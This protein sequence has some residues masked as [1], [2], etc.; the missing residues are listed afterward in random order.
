MKQMDAITACRRRLKHILYTD[1]A[2]LYQGAVASVCPVCREPIRQECDM[3]EVLITRGDVQNSP[4]N[5]RMAVFARENCVLVHHGLCHQQ[6]QH[7]LDSK[8][9]CVLQL[10]DEEGLEKVFIWLDR[11]SGLMTGR[12]P[13]EARRFVQTV[14]ENNYDIFYEVY[15]RA[16]REVNSDEEAALP[17]Y[18][19]FRSRWLRPFYG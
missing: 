5:V 18:P 10:I 14:E 7:S 1:R 11:V 16:D 13:D 17:N 12:F 8:R 2:G 9:D 6:A 3:H 15:F 4:D 19:A